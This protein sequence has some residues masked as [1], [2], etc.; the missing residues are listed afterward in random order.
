MPSPTRPDAV[1]AGDRTASGEAFN[2]AP[3]TYDR[4]AFYALLR[5]DRIG[6]IIKR[7]ELLPQAEIGP[8]VNLAVLAQAVVIALI[9]LAVPLVAG[10]RL[11]AGRGRRGPPGRLLRRTRARL[12]VHR[13][14]SDR[15]GELLSQRPHQRLRARAHGDAD[16][17]GSGQHDR[18]IASPPIRG[19]A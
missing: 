17:L 16:L 7:L 6:T 19:A 8:L 4:P 2:L 18:P 12:P 15:P 1:L 11:R 5:L 3:I 14:F 10:Q 9:V 13:D